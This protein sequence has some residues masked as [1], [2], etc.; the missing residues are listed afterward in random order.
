MC[1]VVLEPC[2]PSTALWCATILALE[3]RSPFFSML[4]NRV[5]YLHATVQ[6]NS[7]LT[8]GIVRSTEYISNK[9]YRSLT[10]WI[11]KNNHLNTKSTHQTHGSGRPTAA[12]TRE[13]RFLAR[14]SPETG[15]KTPES[16][17]PAASARGGGGIRSYRSELG[18]RW[19]DSG[20]NRPKSPARRP[21]KVSCVGGGAESARCEWIRRPRRVQTGGGMGWGLK[22]LNG[23]TGDPKS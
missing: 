22:T 15:R 5:N 7:M 9:H 6:N 13:T 23:L 8:V 17:R 4:P 2:C 20:A 14:K 19:P 21:S 10:T 12:S 11:H 1:Q 16:A 3:T 18:A